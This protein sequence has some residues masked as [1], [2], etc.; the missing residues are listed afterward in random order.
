MRKL[1]YCTPLL[2]ALLLVGSVQAQEISNDFELVWTLTDSTQGAEDAAWQEALAGGWDVDG[3]GVGEFFTSFDGSG[4]ENQD[5][6]LREFEPNSDG[7]FDVV[8]E[9]RVEGQTALSANQR[10]IALG[11]VNGNGANELLF[12]VTPADGSEPNLLVFEAADG[13]FPAMPTASLITPRPTMD[14]FTVDSTGTTMTGSQL[15]WSWEEPSLIDD[16]DGDGNNEFVGAGFRGS[17]DGVRR[18]LG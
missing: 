6:V 3:D 2:T 18:R 8:W 7:S 12:G 4:D 17:R 16:I 10:T 9:Y 14:Y 1:W 11:D 13:S 5:Y 15:E